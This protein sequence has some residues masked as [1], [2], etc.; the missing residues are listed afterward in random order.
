MSVVK[1]FR[2][3]TRLK[4]KASIMIEGLTGKGKSGLALACAKALASDWDKVYAIDTENMSLDLFE[5]LN[6]HTGEKVKAFNKVDLTV[7]DG[8]APSNYE[9]LRNEAIADGAEVVIMD[10]Y[11]HAWT[12]QGGVLDKV[13]K[14]K[15]TSRGGNDYAAWGDDE[16][17]KEKNLIFELV[18]SPKAHIITTV[19]S[20]EKFALEFNSEKNKNDVVSLGEQQMQQ[21]GLK[22]EPDLVLRMVS[23]GNTKG[24]APIALVLK[25]RYPIFEEGLEYEFTDKLLEQLKVYL[26]EGADPEVLLDAQR[27]EYIEGIKKYCGD[28]KTRKSIYKNIKDA[29]GYADAKLEDMPLEIVR[30]VFIQ[31]TQD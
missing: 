30:Q 2:A 29:S 27:K 14:V 18:R 23:A 5:G 26:E 25:S 17:V 11:S 21:E 12:R 7:E 31:L 24:K 6:L 3:S 10:S 8:Y 15:S 19:R 22:Y 13:S 20:K 16:V 9:A 28:N 4:A 1:K